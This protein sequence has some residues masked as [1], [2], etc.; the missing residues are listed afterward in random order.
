MSTRFTPL[1]FDSTYTVEGSVIA[2]VDLDLESTSL[3]QEGSVSQIKVASA[4]VW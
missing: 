1:R 2:I 4:V 3:F